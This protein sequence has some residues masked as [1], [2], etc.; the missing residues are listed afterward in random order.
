VGAALKPALRN[1]AVSKK[2][3]FVNAGDE[4]YALLV[5]IFLF[6]RANFWTRRPVIVSVT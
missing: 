1:V 5:V 4:V 6:Y 3:R 2:R